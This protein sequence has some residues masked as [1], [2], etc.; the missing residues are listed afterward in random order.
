MSGLVT[1]AVLIG[2]LLPAIVHSET[3]LTREIGCH[4]EGG[5]VRHAIASP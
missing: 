1:N 4:G 5:R 3:R 2:L